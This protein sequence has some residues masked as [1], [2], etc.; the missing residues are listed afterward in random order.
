MANNTD[1]LGD[2]LAS[3]F[4][5]AKTISCEN[6]GVKREKDIKFPKGTSE[7]VKKVA[8]FYV[9]HQGRIKVPK[10]YE[11]IKSADR[12]YTDPNPASVRWQVEALL[13]GGC[14]MPRIAQ[15]CGLKNGNVPKMYRDVFFNIEDKGALAELKSVC[16]LRSKTCTDNETD[17]NNWGHKIE[18]LFGGLERFI[19]CRIDLAPTEEDVKF[20]NGLK[21]NRIVLAGL[22]ASLLAGNPN[23]YKKPH[24]LEFMGR[25]GADYRSVQAD[26]THSLR[27]SVAGRGVASL[28]LEEFNDRI[29]KIMEKHNMTAD[30]FLV[31]VFEEE[32]PA[33]ETL[34][35]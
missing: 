13:L 24:L 30:K 25:M 23:N 20:L 12:L 7:L 5:D 9:L 16:A 32:R 10:A 31:S 2:R 8:K 35:L 1:S 6:T 19:R 21:R 33:E 15:L 11:I 29:C 34:P 22:D 14:P 28:G 4:R 17:T 27:E 3:V 26:R 18:V